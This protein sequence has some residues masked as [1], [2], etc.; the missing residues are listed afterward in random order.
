MTIPQTL[1]FCWRYSSWFM[2][3]FCCVR[4]MPSLVNSMWTISIEFDLFAATWV[5]VFGIHMRCDLC[6]LCGDFVKVSWAAST[7]LLCEHYAIVDS[8]LLSS[9]L[10]TL[11]WRL[12]QNV[13]KMRLVYMLSTDWLLHFGRAWADAL[14]VYYIQWLILLPE[15][16]PQTCWCCSWM[17]SCWVDDIA[18][19]VAGVTA[20]FPLLCGVNPNLA[21]GALD[22]ATVL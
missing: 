3:W 13:F 7:P 2:R 21:A 14:M 6:E 20:Y 17:P 19:I 1:V 15:L 9:G 8:L 22:C 5:V 16:L 10:T 18:I 11:R 12:H 4:F